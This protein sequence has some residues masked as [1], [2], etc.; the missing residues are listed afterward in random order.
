M[1]NESNTAWIVS[2]K[3]QESGWLVNGNMSVPNDISNGHHRLILEWIIEGNTPEGP[4]VVTQG[5]VGLRT[6]VDGYASTGDQLGMIA[7]GTQAAHVADVKSRFPKTIERTVSVGDVPSW[8]QEE[9][10]RLL[11]MRAKL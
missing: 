10:D 2:C 6:G 8:V 5:Y 9:V 4:D 11:A 3:A 1:N 7:D